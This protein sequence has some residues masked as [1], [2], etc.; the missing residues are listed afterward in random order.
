MFMGTEFAQHHEWHHDSSLD[1]HIAEHPQRKALQEF[2][3]ELGKLHKATPALWRSDPLPESFE[4]IDCSDRDNT[5][6]TYLRRDGADFVI[7]VLNFTPV[8]RENYRVGVPDRAATSKSSRPTI[9]ASA[10]VSSKR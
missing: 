10:A 3:A 6:L 9:S 8:P 2:I 5:V 4:W 1:W 7:V